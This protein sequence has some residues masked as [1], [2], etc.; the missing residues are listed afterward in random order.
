MAPKIRKPVGLRPPMACIGGALG[1]GNT[2]KRNRQMAI[3]FTECDKIAVEILKNMENPPII[4][5]DAFTHQFQAASLSDNHP[6]ASGKVE[7]LS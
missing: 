7:S 4:T 2:T 5:I 6:D 1:R 3:I